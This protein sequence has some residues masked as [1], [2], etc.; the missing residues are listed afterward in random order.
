[1]RIG[2]MELNNM[3]DYLWILISDNINILINT[4]NL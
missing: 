4:K 2:I 1:M 3:Y